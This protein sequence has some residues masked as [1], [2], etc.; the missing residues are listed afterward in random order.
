MP[1][2]L[3]TSV[4]LAILNAEDDNHAACVNLIEDSDESLVI[5]EPVFVELSLWVRKRIGFSV[6]KVVCDDVSQGFYRLRPIDETTLT[7]SVQIDEQYEGLELGFVDSYVIATCEA[8]SENKV[9]TL[10]RRDFAPVK[11]EHCDSL[12]ILPE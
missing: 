4:L 8:L 11:P 12:T 3:D 5:P 10:D 1:L 9:A 2:I 7:R 6:W